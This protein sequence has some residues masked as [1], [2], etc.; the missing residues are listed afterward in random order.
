VTAVKLAALVPGECARDFP[1][2]LREVAAAR[3]F[4][5]RVL[6]GSPARDMLLICVSELAANA[7]EHTDSGA[8]GVFTVTVGQWA[9]TKAKQTGM[10]ATQSRE[11]AA[12]VAV[13]DEGGAGE[14]GLRRAGDLAE[15]GRG[16]ALVNA[17]SSRWGYRD[18][19]RGR[20]VWAEVAWPSAEPAAPAGG[21]V[22][23]RGP[24]WQDS[25]AN[26]V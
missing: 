22:T 11:G 18:S 21:L 9:G 12:F 16:L 6:D 24:I 7:I 2:N 20:T 14:P 5:A 4:V 17:C 1:G 15:G 26:L 13:T 3:R 25:G 10:Q 19:G 23:L 8:G